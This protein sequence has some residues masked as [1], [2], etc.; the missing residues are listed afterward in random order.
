[1]PT[2]EQT[3]LS[4]DGM[5]CPHCVEVVRE[6]VE[7]VRDVTVHRVEVGTAEV[8]YDPSAVSPDQLATVLDDAGYELTSA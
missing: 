3:T 1:M 5:H 8:T 6:A 7:S 4:I 2:T